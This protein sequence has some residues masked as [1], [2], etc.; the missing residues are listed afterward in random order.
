M[1]RNAEDGENAEEDAEPGRWSSRDFSCFSAFLIKKC[2]IVPAFEIM[3]LRKVNGGF[4]QAGFEA[5]LGGLLTMKADHVVER[6]LPPAPE[7][8]GGKKVVFG[9][10]DPV[11]GGG[12]HTS[13]G[14]WW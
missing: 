10:F 12:L 6:K 1:K 8:D 14:L 5:F 13:R 3:G 11:T 7:I 2:F 4:L 9:L